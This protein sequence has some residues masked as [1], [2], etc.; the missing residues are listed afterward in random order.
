MYH[1]GSDVL[2]VLIARAAGRPFDVFL[3]ERLFEPLGMKDTAFSV[4]AGEARPL[5]YQLLGD[6]ATGAVARLRR[7]PRAASGAARPRFPSGGG[8]LVSTVDDFLAFARMLLDG[9]KRGHDAHPVTALGRGHDHGP[10][11]A[12]AEGGVRRPGQWLLR[13]P[14]VG[15]RHGGGHP[16]RRRSRRVPASTAGTAGSARP[17]PRIPR[18]EMVGI[19]MTQRARNSPRRRRSRSTSGPRPI[20]PS[21]TRH[22]RS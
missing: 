12:R 5:R 1:T 22:A 8:G 18:E 19:L 6:P 21:T 11:H 3:R 7:R 15:L 16:P 10:A 20:R 2:G 17:G 13:Q 14:R 9:G 4:P